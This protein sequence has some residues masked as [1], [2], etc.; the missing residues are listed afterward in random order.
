MINRIFNIDN[1]T[2]FSPVPQGAE[3][4]SI[5]KIF[6][7][8]SKNILYIS[9]DNKEAKLIYDNLK[10]ILPEETLFLPSWDVKPYD[11][12]SP[13]QDILHK[14]ISTFTELAHNRTP[15]IVITSLEILAQKIIPKEELEKNSIYIKE[16]DK[17]S[18]DD[19]IRRLVEIG[20]E[21]TSTASSPG[22]FAVRGSIVDIYAN[23]FKY[24]HR[25]DFFDNIV[26]FIKSFDP[27]SQISKDRKTSFL[28]SPPSEIILSEDKIKKFKDYSISKIGTKALN[29]PII[30]K[31]DSSSRV[32]GI[33]QW[34]N[35]FYEKLETIFSYL[36]NAELLIDN[37]AIQKLNFHLNDINEQY[38][39]RKASADKAYATILPNIEELYLTPKEIEKNL[40]TMNSSIF[41]AGI[42]NIEVIESNLKPLGNID[43]I[44]RARKQTPIQYIA[45]LSQKKPIIVSSMTEGN[46]QRILKLFKDHNINL[47]LQPVDLLKNPKNSFSCIAPFKSG[48]ETE[49]FFLITDGDIFGERIRSTKIKRNKK[50][51][52]VLYEAHN[53]SEGELVV[54]EDHGIGKFMGIET[55]E[56]QNIRHDCLKILY[57]GD[58]KLFIPVE[59]INLISKYGIE[60][61]VRLDKL[62]SSS[63]QARKA[64]IKDKLKLSAEYLVKIAA[65]R[66]IKSAPI[67]EPKAGLF[68]E[69]CCTFPYAE[70]DDQLNAINDVIEDLKKETP[71]DRLI[72]GD[73][74]F[75]KTEV[76]LRAAFIAATSSPGNQVA[77]FCPTTLLCR[78]HFKIFSE[79]LKKF[80]I[81]VKQLSRLVKQ[82]EINKTIAEINDGKVD[83]VIGTHSLLNKS[84]KFKNLTLLIVD[85]EQHFGVAQKEK[86]K[87]ISSTAHI[88]TLSATPIPRTLQMSLSG[89]K[90]LS[91]IATP[92]VNRLVTKTSVLTYDPAIIKEALL[93]EYY[94]GGQSFYVCPRI[95]DLREIEESLQILVPNLKYV[96][97]HG[98]M[99]PSRLDE[100]MNDFYEGKYD[101]L[102]ST[103]IVESGLDIPKA[104]TII[105]HKSHQFGMS[106]LYQLRGRVGRSNIAAYSYLTVPANKKLTFSTVNRLEVLQNIDSLGAGFNIAAHDMENRGYGNLL[107]EEQ[108]GHVREI[109]IELYQELLTEEINKIKEG[110]TYKPKEPSAEINLGISALIP[111]EYISDLD[112]RLNIYRQLGGLASNEEIEQFAAEMIDRFGAIPEDF[113]NLISIIKIKQLAKIAHIR[114]IDAGPKAILF[115]INSTNIQHPEKLLQYILN[116]PNNIKMRSSDEII[117][118]PS[119]FANKNKIEIITEFLHK[120]ISIFDAS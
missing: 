1:S 19:L 28:I 90:E 27:D 42:D 36:P 76:A 55:I 111:E 60:D 12:L 104:N 86:L 13:S 43:K 29:L 38:E 94:R 14:R 11:L 119:K 61:G 114:K 97:A 91:L 120:I 16:K 10:S 63:W 117:F 22:E 72:C 89:I 45:L 93:R 39:A 98:Q 73:V 33:E 112:V 56:V 71:M 113:E 15:K 84:I 87:E 26:E 53:F 47:A 6:T 115:K 3:F 51:Q 110:E 75:G 9:K 68:E 44:S 100:I 7:K 74:G 54:H 80:G 118:T 49:S 52:Q 25:I 46:C 82:S 30:E 24:G 18:R 64:K 62:G 40:S 67:L 106:Q 41:N 107:G 59:D 20:Y 116:N 4:Y 88:L 85:E 37:L 70:T 34:Y 48:F 99:S 103:T 50:L 83:V 35:V 8:K 101:I 77:I 65:E 58:D 81:R 95:K 96:I 105:I 79:R 66:A 31:I 102:L 21:R 109:G 78:Q 5:A 69:F 2:N 108:S 57:Y 32:I 17:I 23:G 92:P